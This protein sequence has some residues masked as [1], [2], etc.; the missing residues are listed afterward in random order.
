MVLVSGPGLTC[1]YRGVPDD[2]MPPRR[3]AA[4][5]PAVATDAASSDGAPARQSFARPSYQG[6]GGG[7]ERYFNTNDLGHL[8][9][10]GILH[11]H[12][13]AD[14]QVKIRGQKVSL[15]EV[16]A[17]LVRTPYVKQA[18]VVEISSARGGV[19]KGEAVL[20]AFVTPSTVD[21]YEVR[22]AAKEWLTDAQMPAIITRLRKVY[23][24]ASLPCMTQPRLN[25]FATFLR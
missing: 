20:C 14:S 7:G 5:A 2:S 18:V 1:G 10:A 3:P 24:Q 15:L 23:V 9:A 11:F 21:T 19:S 8:D 4:A 16:E 13:R 22:A 6:G 17:I 25:V 12:G